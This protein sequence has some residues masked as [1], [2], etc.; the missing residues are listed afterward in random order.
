MANR[1]RQRRRRIRRSSIVLRWLGLAAIVLIAF[2]YYRPVRTYFETRQELAQR[3][4]EVK[5]LV[6]ERRA[7]ERRLAASATKQAL[8]REARRLG[9]V[10]PGERLFIVKGVEAWRKAEATI[11]RDE[12]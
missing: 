5:A 9:F 10:K 8:T 3:H 7:L 1:S 12:R 6:A 11:A 4:S 2:L